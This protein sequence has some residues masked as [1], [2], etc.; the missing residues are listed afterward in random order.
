MTEPMPELS[1][2]RTKELRSAARAF[3]LLLWPPLPIWRRLDAAVIA[4]AVYTALVT[5]VV[6]NTDVKV[7]DWSSASTIVSGIVLGMLL[8]FRTNVAHDRWWEGRRLWGQLINESRTLSAKIAALPGISNVDRLEIGRLLTAYSLALRNR[9]RGLPGLQRVSGFEKA[10]ENPD[11]VPLFL[12][13]RLLTLLQVER[14][15]GRITEIDLLNLDPHLRGFMEVCGSC[16][17][18]KNTPMPL[19]YRSLMRH[20]LVLYLLTT[21]WLLAD[22]LQWWDV[23]VMA[24]L[25]YFLLGV[26]LIAEDVEEPFGRDTDD[27][28]LSTYCE[29]IR[30]SVEQLLGTS[31]SQGKT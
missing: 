26:E 21:P 14:V 30:S 8:G 17:R 16:E 18:I 25:G 13:A 12:H 1:P 22:H 10:T 15:A 5:L 4:C 3:L 6:S 24:M 29:T 20:G 11:H 23:P 28:A 7:P 9:L 31:G 27:L 19:S 2:P